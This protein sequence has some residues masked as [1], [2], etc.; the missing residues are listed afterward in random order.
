MVVD[1]AIDAYLSYVRVEKGLADN[2]IDAYGRDLLALAAS[3][4]I[5]GVAE[6][7]DVRVNHVLAHL[8]ELS[9]N[10]SGVRTQARLIETVLEPGETGAATAGH[11]PIRPGHAT[12]RGQAGRQGEILG[13]DGGGEVVAQ[14]HGI[15]GRPGEPGRELGFGLRDRTILAGLGEQTIGLGRRHA[16]RRFHED[17]LTS[18]QSGA[19][20]GRQDLQPLSPAPHHGGLT[21]HEERT[22]G[23][24]LRR[25]R[26]ERLGAERIARRTIEQA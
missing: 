21:A 16:E 11:L 3:L 6:A 2:T 20:G 10:G 15:G 9:R 24:D 17:D 14:L 18:G 12:E 19:R 23:P 13:E 22:V 1:S 7:H 8:V 26:F 5:Q 25:E 4:T